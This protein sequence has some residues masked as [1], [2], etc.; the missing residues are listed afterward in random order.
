MK[1]IFE[2]ILAGVL[3]LFVYLVA[4]TL[5]CMFVNAILNF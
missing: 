2:V 3:L 5:A 4:S 1:I